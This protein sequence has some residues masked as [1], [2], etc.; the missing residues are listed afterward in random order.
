VKITP[1]LLLLS[2]LAASA[3]AGTYSDKVLSDS[4]FAYYRLNESSNTGAAADQV[5]S[6][7]GAY[8]NAPTSGV[9]GALPSDPGSTAF[10]FAKTSSQH[11]RLTTMGTFGSSQTTGYSVEYWLKTS[12]TTTFQTV[13]GTI[14][15]TGNEAFSVDLN[16]A[17]V[18]GRVRLYDRDPNA[19]RFESNF[20][21]STNGN[22]NVFDG[23]WHHVVHVYEPT[24]AVANRIRM[25]VDGVRQLNDYLPTATPPTNANYQFPLIL[26]G[27]NN[28]GTVQD[29]LNGSL[30]EVA[31]YKTILSDAAIAAHYAAAVQTPPTITGPT[32]ADVTDAS[33]T[34]GGNVTNDGRSPITERG[35]LI[36]KTS[37]D[38]DPQLGDPNVTKLTAAGTTGAFTVPVAGLEEETSYSYRAY[39]TNGLGTTYTGV[40]TFTTPRRIFLATI[41]GPTL[42]GVTH[43]S[44]TVGGDVTDDGRTVIT[45]RGVLIA[46]TSVD[47]DPKLGDANVAKVTAAGTTGVFTAPVAGLDEETEYSYRAYATNAAGTSYTSVATV[48]T[49]RYIYL[50]AVTGPTITGV[51]HA[52]ATLGGEVTDDGRTAI[53]ERGVLIAKTTLDAD[54]QLGGTNV[55]KVTAAGATGVYTVPVGGLDEETSYS[56][57][58]YATNAAGT[59]YTAV[60]TFTTPRLIFPPTIAGPTLADLAH[61]SATLGADVTNDG[62]TAITERG[63]L[64]AETSLDADPKLGDAN[65]TKMAASGTI[66]VFTAPVTGLNQET[67]YSYRA[68]AT[69]AAGTSYTAVATF[70]TPTRIDFRGVDDRAVTTSGTTRIYPLAND[71]SPTKAPLNLV[72]VSDPAILI[73]DRSLIIP[74]GYT[75]TFTYLFTDGTSVGEASVTVSAGVAAANPLN[76]SGL[77]READETI[78][79]FAELTFTASGRVAS[80]R[81][82]AGKATLRTYVILPA[83]ALTITR[84]TALGTITVTR[85]ANQTVSFKLAAAGGDL[86]GVLSARRA[87]GAAARFHVALGSVDAGIPGGGYAVVSVAKNGAASLATLLPDGSVLTASTS[88]RDNGTLAFY[89]VVGRGVNPAAAVAGELVVAD[90]AATDITGEVAWI[91]PPQRVLVRGLHLDGVD[92]LLTANG[93]LFRGE[94]PPSGPGTLEI[95]GGNLAPSGPQPVTVTGGRPA[96]PAGIVQSWKVIGNNTQFIATL[97][98]PGRTGAIMGTGLY[99]PKS[100]SAWGFF[101]GTDVGGRIELNL[102]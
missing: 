32:L 66:G 72:R 39:A 36:V 86:T 31:F 40:A 2:V 4:P 102:P 98:V 74:A 65:V 94:V 68:Y 57:R 43:A 27:T 90:L 45:E 28:R 29:F 67:A 92:T 54:P 71:V 22:I 80:L 83:G 59:T 35:V 78:A 34:L 79:G 60:A 89:S 62:R 7:A 26:G 56:Y 58:A 48:T 37:V 46:K 19:N 93:S 23:A 84:S 81:L 44:A 91:K 55:A 10:S 50:P 14:N 75:G 8:V 17:G 16:Y 96:V 20:Y 3:F 61:A 97:K 24:A 73:D 15:S 95:S 12:D 25:Y 30:D 13:L 21:T 41:T 38:A 70:T 77:L 69:N 76:F 52:S 100:N 6:N 1:V 82:L 63:V 5:G 87:A 18:A 64:I 47:A 101:L 53:T 85:N 49:P 51:T 42:T 11:V 99:L 9:A 33:A 88:L